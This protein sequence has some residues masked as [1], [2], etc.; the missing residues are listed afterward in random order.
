MSRCHQLKMRKTVEWKGDKHSH[1]KLL[2]RMGLFKMFPLMVL[3]LRLSGLNNKNKI[4]G[5]V[6]VLG[7]EWGLSLLKIGGKFLES[8]PVTRKGMYRQKTRFLPSV[9]A[10]RSEQEKAPRVETP[11]CLQPSPLMQSQETPGQAA[12]AQPCN[13]Q[14]YRLGGAGGEERNCVWMMI[15]DW[16]WMEPSDQRAPEQF[17]WPAVLGCRLRQ[18]VLPTWPGNKASFKF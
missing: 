1:V 8:S 2:S 17:A 15:A 11:G 14:L 16:D 5:E 12:S 18:A 3:Y 4:S 9:L 13:P 7:K 10:K 6:R